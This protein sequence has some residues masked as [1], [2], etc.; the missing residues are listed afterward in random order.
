MLAADSMQNPGAHSSS[1]ASLGSVPPHGHT[2]DH[3]QTC[4]LSGL[5][6]SAPVQQVC[7]W[8]NCGDGRC[9]KHSVLYLSFVRILFS[10]LTRGV[11]HAGLSGAESRKNNFTTK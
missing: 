10:D 9:G 7:L 11:A 2:A 3:T 8:W 4:P 6:L 5:A 1:G